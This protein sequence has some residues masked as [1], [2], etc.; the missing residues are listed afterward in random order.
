MDKMRGRIFVEETPGG[1][2]TFKLSLPEA[3]AQAARAP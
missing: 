2:A 1:G 3:P